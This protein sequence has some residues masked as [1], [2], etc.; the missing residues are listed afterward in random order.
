MRSHDNEAACSVGFF[1]LLASHVNASAPVKSL[2]GRCLVPGLYAEHLERWML[3]FSAAQVRLIRCKGLFFVCNDVI[4]GFQLTIY[5]N[6][7]I[8]V[9]VKVCRPNRRSGAIN[10]IL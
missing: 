2:R 5:F 7:L 6:V 9:R 4:L 3:H 1:D 10:V 8:E